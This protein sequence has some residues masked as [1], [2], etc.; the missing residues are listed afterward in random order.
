MED[1]FKWT[2]TA[3]KSF[4]AWNLSFQTGKDHFR[5]LTGAFRPSYNEAATTSD[6]WYYMLRLM[7]NI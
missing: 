5:P 2:F 6:A 3:L 7:V 4:G 1:D